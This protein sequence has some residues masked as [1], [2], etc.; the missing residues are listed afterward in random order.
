MP[1]VRVTFRS[2][3]HRARRQESKALDGAIRTL[4]VGLMALVWLSALVPMAL[5]ALGATAVSA[6]K[7]ATKIP[8]P[9]D[10]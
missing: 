1:V 3:N 7:P 6:L 8:A 2:Q 4:Q 5:L 9:I 10:F